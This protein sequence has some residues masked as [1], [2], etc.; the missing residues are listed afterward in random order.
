MADINLTPWRRPLV[1]ALLALGLLTQLVGCGGGSANSSAV[2][3]NAPVSTILPTGSN[4]IAISVEAGPGNN[5]N[6]PYVSV[7]VCTSGGVVGSG[8][9]KDI[10][11]V[12][13][14]TGSTGLRLFASVVSAAPALTLTPQ[15]VGSNPAISAISECA[16]FLNN[17]AWGS[18]KLAD[19]VIAGERAQNVPVQLM[20]AND[21]HAV[22]CWDPSKGASLF[23]TAGDVP[24][25][26]SQ[27]LGANGI[28]GLSLFSNDGQSY[29]NCTQ[30]N[31]LCAPIS[32]TK[33]Q[34]V[35]NPV[36]LFTNDN[37]GVVVQLPPVSAS[38]NNSAAGA[39]IFGVGTRSN[40]ALGA[41]NVVPVNATSGYFTTTYKGRQLTHSFMDSG[42][43]GLY[44]SDP[45]LSTS[46]STAASGFY[47]PVSTQNLTASIQLASTSATV[48][49]SI[50]NADNLFSPG[51]ISSG[52]YA[53]NNLG[54]TMGSNS[55]DWGLPFFF[56]RSVYTVIEGHSVGTTPGPF[57]A[58][59]N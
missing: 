29:F 37:N 40:N 45:N 5:V 56:G 51:G 27:T 15:T 46:C 30:S 4:V 41:A 10:N 58:F 36:G 59:T 50:A 39:L 26:N 19:V 34:Q 11:H 35:Q 3:G 52:N 13:L 23:V 55:F 38:G 53:F 42:S 7:T 6:I 31:S 28:L 1:F 32:L 54:G 22:N 48:N 9:C 21:V 33:A 25:A 2:V 12:L 8:S 24:K 47:C 43:N 17:N 57:Y 49:F 18:V 16:N 14:D 20:D 44:F